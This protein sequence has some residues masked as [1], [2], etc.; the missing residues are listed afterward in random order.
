MRKILSDIN[1]IIGKTIKN[2]QIIDDD[3]N[4]SEL[5]ILDFENNESFI[6][7]PWGGVGNNYRE[8]SG[9]NIVEQ[10]SDIET[11]QDNQQFLIDLG[12][13]TQIQIDEE[14]KERKRI[15]AVNRKKAEIQ[16]EKEE[17]KLYEQLKKKYKSNS[18]E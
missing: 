9:F 12:F 8:E 17:R 10:P 13:K 16:K 3:Y 1:Q 7:K 15:I 2:A 18:I 5:L 4:D 6:V 14:E 11:P